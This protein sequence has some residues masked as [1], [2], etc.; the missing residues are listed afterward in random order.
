M[1]IRTPAGSLTPD[2]IRQRTAAD[3]SPAMKAIAQQLA[4]ADAA[5]TAE[6]EAVAAELVAV[7]R[8]TRTVGR[9]L[10]A[11][12]R[13]GNVMCEGVEELD[14]DRWVA[15]GIERV[16]QLASLAAMPLIEAS[17]GY[18]DDPPRLEAQ[19]GHLLD[20]PIDTDVHVCETC[21]LLAAEL[22]ESRRLLR[23]IGAAAITAGG[24]CTDESVDSHGRRELGADAGLLATV[25]SDGVWIDKADSLLTMTHVADERAALLLER[26]PYPSEVDTNVHVCETCAQ[27]EAEL[28]GA[29]RWINRAGDI[30]CYL[31][32][33]AGF[34]APLMDVERY[35]ASGGDR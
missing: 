3:A 30:L 14:L 34:A 23:G 1:T 28:D 25:D 26:R 24:G 22:D 18:E 27:L 16:D 19:Y 2:Q 13:T 7:A 5:F 17:C 8:I 20:E 9:R 33:V 11:V 35:I 21:E 29:R 15:L 32:T 12:M 10:D 6:A 4:A 31:K